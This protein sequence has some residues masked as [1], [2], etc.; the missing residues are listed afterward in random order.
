MQAPVKTTIFAIT[1]VPIRISE[2]GPDHRIEKPF[3]APV[4]AF[5]RIAKILAAI[6]IWPR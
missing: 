3:Q 5:Q 6:S 4:A 2:A 1:Q